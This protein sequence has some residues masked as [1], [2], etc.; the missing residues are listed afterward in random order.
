M[1][2]YRVRGTPCTK[3]PVEASLR[4]TFPPQKNRKTSKSRG[5][6][7][8][9]WLSTAKGTTTPGNQGQSA[10]ALADL[11]KDRIR[12]AANAFFTKLWGLEGPRSRGAPTVE[13]KGREAARDKLVETC[14]ERYE[15]G[16][17][18]W[19][20]SSQVQN[21][22]TKACRRLEEQ[23][24]GPAKGPRVGRSWRQKMA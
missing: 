18:C 23:I 7:L 16:C 22:R 20:F 14:Q 5:M 2:W 8:R 17:G 19:V 21:T 15:E 12:S 4:L 6:D 3:N 9:S 13:S 10:K 11:T 1:A 24:R